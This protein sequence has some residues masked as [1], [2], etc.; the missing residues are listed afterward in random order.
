MTRA[1]L[2]IVLLALPWF[3][4][5]DSLTVTL[6]DDAPQSVTLA[7]QPPVIQPMLDSNGTEYETE[8]RCRI[9]QIVQPA[10]NDY[11]TAS[12]TL[13]VDDAAAFTVPAGSDMYIVMRYAFEDIAY[14]FDGRYPQASISIAGGAVPVTVIM[15]DVP[16][17]VFALSLPRADT[18]NL[19]GKVGVLEL[20]LPA[21]DDRYYINSRSKIA[22]PAAVSTPV[23]AWTQW[24]IG[25]GYWPIFSPPNY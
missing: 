9:M 20:S 13:D 23:D 25:G 21:D 11:S 14:P 6:A 22:F 2:C 12:F 18:A 17:A 4:A 7:N 3:A 5:A 16:N 1:L 24:L 19:A 15:L 10:A 8:Q